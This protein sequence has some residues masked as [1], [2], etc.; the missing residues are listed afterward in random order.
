METINVIMNLIGIPFLPIVFIL[1]ILILVNGQQKFIRWTIILFAICGISMFMWFAFGLLIQ[2][3]QE[4]RIENHMFPYSQMTSEQIS[5]ALRIEKD[6]K[7]RYKLAMFAMG[8]IYITSTI[9]LIILF[10]KT[11]RNWTNNK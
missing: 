2:S 8:L 3:S 4:Y 1:F 10:A 9:S 5:D 6:N 11:I 7:I